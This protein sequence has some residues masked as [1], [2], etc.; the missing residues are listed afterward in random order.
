MSVLLKLTYAHMCSFS[1]I[2]DDL[3]SAPSSCLYSWDYP[4][5]EVPFFL[6]VTR[7][8]STYHC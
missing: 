3:S 4:A 7:Y 5:P 8:M 6:T 1:S 2:P